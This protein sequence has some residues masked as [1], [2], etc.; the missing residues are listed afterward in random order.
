MTQREFDKKMREIFG[1]PKE[2]YD[3]DPYLDCRVD[4]EVSHPAA[5]ALMCD[6]LKS[7][8]YGDGVAVFVRAHKWYA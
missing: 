3:Y 8:G 6:L 4:E 5:D 1:A 2:G 7:L